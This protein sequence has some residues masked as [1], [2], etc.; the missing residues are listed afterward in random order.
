MTIMGSELAYPDTAE[1]GNSG[2]KLAANEINVSPL[3]VADVYKKRHENDT[4]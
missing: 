2:L 4:R 3:R 1:G